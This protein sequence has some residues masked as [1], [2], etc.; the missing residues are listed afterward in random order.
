M[1]PIL[2]FSK[3]MKKSTAHLHMVGNEIVKFEKILTFK[4]LRSQKFLELTSGGHFEFW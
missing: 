3:N 4:F 2:N 1:A